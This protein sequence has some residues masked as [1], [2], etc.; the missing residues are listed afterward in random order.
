MRPRHHLL[1]ITLIPALACGPFIH[2]PSKNEPSFEGCVEPAAEDLACDEPGAEW[3]V[4]DSSG[5]HRESSL[6]LLNHICD[7]GCNT[8][9]RHLLVEG[10]SSTFLEP[11]QSIRRVWS[12]TLRRT[13][14]NQL[15][16]LSGLEELEQGFKVEENDELIDFQGLGNLVAVRADGRRTTTFH[17]HRNRKL[18]SLKGLDSLAFIGGPSESLLITDNPA[19]TEVRLDKLQH[20]E[21]DLRILRNP[22]L[23]EIA[24]MNQLEEIGS[25]A[26]PQ[27]GDLTIMNNPHLQRLTAFTSLRKV[28]GNVRVEDNP[29]LSGC[30]IQRLLNQLTEVGGTITVSRNGPAIDCP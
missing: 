28:K 15:T 18:L 4:L 14:L 19:L 27:S 30:D 25:H 12:L 16:F 8:I 21:G 17:I 26:D 2:D 5:D 20:L 13:A 24:G 23:E 29:Q 10:G 6:A 11:L 3:T 7:S 22:V 9:T 1:A